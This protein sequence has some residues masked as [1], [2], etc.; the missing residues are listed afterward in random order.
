MAGKPVRTCLTILLSEF[1]P[2]SF[3]DL[4]LHGTVVERSET[5]S[6]GLIPLEAYP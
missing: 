1:L 3:M 6:Q 4:S 2:E 5:H